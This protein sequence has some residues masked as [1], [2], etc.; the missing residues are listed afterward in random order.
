VLAE[1]E[2][3]SL[4]ELISIGGIGLLAVWMLISSLWS[5]DLGDAALSAERMLVYVAGLTALAL[6]ARRGSAGAVLAGTLAALTVVVGD[7]LTG[8][9]FPSTTA[10]SGIAQTGR[11]AAPTGYWNGMGI[12]ATLGLLLALGLAARSRTLAGRA[13]AAL[14]MPVLATGLYQT[15]SRGAWISL[16][17]GLVVALAADRRRWQLLAT[18]LVALPWLALDVGLGANSS[19][20]THL[21]SPIST[22]TSQGH[23]LALVMVASAV[24]LV[25]A[26]V[27][28]GVFMRRWSPSASLTRIGHW[29]AIAL[30]VV[31][32]IAPFAAYGSPAQI[33][34]R[35]S[36]GFSSAAPGGFKST[37]GHQG[38]SLNAR[39]FSLSGNARLGLWKAAWHEYEANPVTGAGAGQFASYYLQHRSGTLRAQWAHSLYLETLADLGPLGLALLLAGLLPAVYAGWRAR[40]HPLVPVGLGAYAAF[41]LHT[42][43]DW[44]W[45]LTGVAM[46]AL[47]VAMALMLAARPDPA[48][49]FDL[50]RARTAAITA[51]VV[52]TLITAYGLRVNLAISRSADAAASGDWATAVSEANTATS[53]APWMETSW[54][55]LG[56]ARIG[57]GRFPAAIAAFRHAQ[58]DNRH[59]WQPWFGIARASAGQARLAALRQAR[60]L[61]P[62]EPVIQPPPASR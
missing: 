56:E 41:L 30:I 39:L 40:S 49:V 60:R 12:T 23:R 47:A 4:P 37:A 25:A 43:G 50:P 9:L 17:F 61:D 24:P 46:A 10:V 34:T 44:D 11:L 3:P 36:N 57:Q 58:S 16:A 20:L 22:A 38:K 62:N 54:I 21:S 48:P 42:G 28:L 1:C 55:A 35:L 27:G 2:Q 15:F 13:A 26:V 7:G 18:A 53:W 19:A 33:W 14:T 45:Q 59:D 52:L 29:A 6:V 51:I 5:H 31:A 32:V 8:Y